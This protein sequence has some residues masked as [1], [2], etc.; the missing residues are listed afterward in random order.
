MPQ[1]RYEIAPQYSNRF[2]ADQLCYDKDEMARIH[3]K[4]SNMLPDE[5]RV[6]YIHI[7]DSVESGTGFLFLSVR[8]WMNWENIYLEDAICWTTC[9]RVH[10]CKCGVKWHNI[11]ATSRWSYNPFMIECTFS[12]QW[13]VKWHNILATSRWLYNPFMI[14]CTFSYQW[15]VKLWI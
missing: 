15:S 4:L 9:K 2:I 14:E 11:L 7:V 1:P 12:Y 5:H 13:S 3:M 10:C 6:I 8:L